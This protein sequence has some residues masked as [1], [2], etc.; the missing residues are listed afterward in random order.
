MSSQTQLSK[1]SISGMHCTSCSLLLKKTLES[2]N[3]VSEANVN[4]ATGKALIKYDPNIVSERDLINAVDSTGYQ[5][6]ITTSDAKTE[7]LKRREEIKYWTKKFLG[8]LI[9]SVP[10]MV[11]MA[12]DF[13][14]LFPFHKEIMPISALISFIVTTIVLFGFG[15]NFFKGA[16]TALKVRSFSMDS[17][18]AIGTSSAYFFSLYIYIKFILE[19][20]SFLGLNNMGVPGLYFEVASFLV[21]FVTLGK[22]LEAKAKGKTSEALDKLVQIKPQSANL[23]KNNKVISISVD[24][25]KIGDKVLVKSGEL[26]S[27]DGIV[28]DGISSVDESLLTGESLPVEKI[29]DSKVYAGT[30]NQLGSL[31]IKVSK[32]SSNTTFSQ[33]IKLLDEAQSSRAPIQNLADKISAY[34]VPAI[35]V[36]AIITLLFT[37]SLLAFISVLVIACPC[38][39]GLATP[40]SIMVATGLAAKFGIL[41]K[42]GE[43]L[44]KGSTIDTIVFDKTGTLT[45]GKPS[46]TNFQ[47]LSKLSDDKIF[48][49]VNALELRSSHPLAQ[50]I[51][52]YVSSF[53]ITNLQISNFQNLTG[54]GVEATI[55]G[56]KYYL[57]KTSDYQIALVE[58]KN[59]LAFFEITDKL[60]DN[61]AEVIRTLQNKHYSVYLISGDS[62]IISQKIA[63]EVG[64]PSDHVFSDV[65]PQDKASI[66][67][68]LQQENK[69][70]AFVGDGINDSIVLSQSDLGIAL[71][72]GSDIAI[73]SGQ[74]VIM[75]NNL[76]S[77]LN[78]LEIS[79][80]TVGKIKQNLFFALI[81]NALGIP[82]AAGVFA[83]LGIYLKP[84]LA[85]LA[86]AL[87]SVSVVT[88]SLLLRFY[89]PRSTNWASLL[90]PVAMTVIFLGIFFEFTQIS[91]TKNLTT[92][93]SLAPEILLNTQV[94]IGYTPTNIPKLFAL[95]SSISSDV[96]SMILGYEEAKMM[97][98][99]GLIN[100]VGDK[101]TDFFGLPE[102]TIVGILKPTNTVLDEFHFFDAKSYAL[103]KA[104]NSLSVKK[105]SDGKLKLFLVSDGPSDS[106]LAIK[107]GF[108][109]GQMMLKEKL[110]SG[111]GST[112][113]DFFGND[114]VITNINRRTYTAYDMLHFVPSNFKY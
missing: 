76:F 58:G 56:K 66:V 2:L 53:S 39:L 12:Y 55:G 107:L 100:N 80:D 98:A 68:G 40:T 72:S 36:I 103:L 32:T 22:L 1:L 77:V 14:P 44:E 17:L 37:N 92:N 31:T 7:I 83:S 23:V 52:D 46:V 95:D 111:P 8:S 49:I 16:F 35:I 84:E 15:K 96:P 13:F 89:K 3:G 71:S 42:G 94:K 81:Y 10:L 57:G 74:V 90:A 73:E 29:L 21:T 60:K 99:E 27:V 4:Y 62:K 109:E 110:I 45:V 6:S 93:F 67:K 113:N 88:N 63:A 108:L 38:A 19:T 70:V 34:F 41:F 20:G 30:L 97:K 82:I 50:A 43:A 75:N 26:I 48:S 51:I 9:L 91:N 18:I 78:S 86:M 87:S 104:E 64:I 79:R 59:T 24:L 101:L 25:L 102:V 69:K 105:A 28:V 5:A 61:A 54:Q 11:F 33:I 114:V 106:P 112:L 65:L 47:N 85:G